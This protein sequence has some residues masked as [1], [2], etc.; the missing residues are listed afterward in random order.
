MADITDSMG[1]ILAAKSNMGSD[2]DALEMSSL[3]ESQSRFW[4]LSLSTT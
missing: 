4:V 3:K 1:L 2:V